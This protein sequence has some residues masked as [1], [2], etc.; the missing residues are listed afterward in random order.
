MEMYDGIDKAM[1]TEYV[2]ELPKRCLYCG[3]KMPVN[4]YP[5]GCRCSQCSAYF[6]RDFKT[7]EDFDNDGYYACF[8]TRH[9]DISE[10]RL[11]ELVDGTLV[12]V[13]QGCAEWLFDEGFMNEYVDYSCDPADSFL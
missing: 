12:E 4:D 10:L 11:F 7:C 1:V 3:S 2:C 6:H 13:C 9:C 5:Y 8:C